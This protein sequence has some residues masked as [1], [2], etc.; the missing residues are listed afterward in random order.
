[1]IKDHGKI[2]GNG[3]ALAI[4]AGISLGQWFDMAWLRQIM[5]VFLFM[6]LYPAMLDLNMKRVSLTLH[7]PG[8]VLTALF[9]NLF[10][11]PL[12]IFGLLKLLWAEQGRAV[13]AGLFLYASVPCGAMVPVFTGILKGDVGLSTAILTLSLFGNIAILPLWSKCL[14][15]N[16]VSM[17]LDS[18]ATC[19]CEI[20]AIPFLVALV[21]RC[22]LCRQLKE[23]AGIRLGNYLK[24]VADS[25][26][27][28]FTFTV[29]CL[30]GRQIVERPI[31]ILKVAC[32]VL[33]FLILLVLVASLTAVWMKASHEDSVSLIL[34]TTAKNNVIAMAMALSAFG[35]DAALVISM[36]SFVQLPFMLSYIK[37]AKLYHRKV[38]PL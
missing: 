22:F 21:T 13:M 27:I 25:G 8:V 6:M 17:P 14:I 36:A 33:L 30:N 9:I 31:I 28:L 18:L 11:S 3:V 37:L 7:K 12:L 10:F 4:T 24:P 15:G 35:T 29:F 32:P 20:I 16:V 1:M 5:P 26:L 38:S 23:K 2:T 34:S 19:L